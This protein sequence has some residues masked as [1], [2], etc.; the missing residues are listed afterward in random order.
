MISTNNQQR[1]SPL[2]G[3]VLILVHL[4]AGVAIGCLVIFD[5]YGTTCIGHLIGI[6]LFPFTFVL[7]VSI[8]IVSLFFLLTYLGKYLSKV[9]EN[10]E[11]LFVIFYIVGYQTNSLQLG[12]IDMSDLALGVFLVVVLIDAF[13]KEKKSFINTPINLFN[14]LL[15]VFIL[16]PLVHLR[17]PSRTQFIY[18]K[19]VL[20]FFLMVNALYSKELVI[21][22]VKWLIIITSFSAVFAIFQEFMWVT[23]GTLVTGMIPKAELKR[24]FEGG[25]FRVPALMLSYRIF[26][27]ILAATL[28]ITISLLIFPN[29]LVTGMKK[30]IY[31]Y[32]VSFLM[33]GALLLT[34]AKDV[35]LGFFVALIFLLILRRPRYIF[36]FAVVILLL[37][38]VL[39]TL[40]A[41]LPGKGDT[42][43]YVVRDIPKAERERIQLDR[44][45][46]QGFVRGNYKLS[47]CGKGGKY[48]D[49]ALGW[50]AHNAFILILDEAGIFGFI[51]Y[52]GMY[53]WVLFR[54]VCLNLV[55][56]DTAYVPI[57]RGL[58]CG[59]IIYII[60]AQ[61]TAGY[62]EQF[63]WILFALT[64]ST[65]LI[66]A[67]NQVPLIKREVFLSQ[68]KKI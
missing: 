59:I 41:Y 9:A 37:A 61:F 5:P 44:D 21:K 40:F 46:I 12:I 60:G 45:G 1:S 7:L 24:M 56:K 13:V 16:L 18:V 27:I 3:Y 2:R 51:I 65:A 25:L 22:C 31:L 10:K 47:G 54:L 28:I 32:S 11:L 38:A 55:V 15:L 8:V 39:F 30:K 67:K 57:V 35:L 20:M 53:I 29:S 66:L 52:L 17:V 34:L 63:L 26:A 68:K 49:N 64:E 14:L 19:I 33:F 48:T 43:S 6:K 36:H 23:T 58:L 62:I 50:P 4:I 42:I